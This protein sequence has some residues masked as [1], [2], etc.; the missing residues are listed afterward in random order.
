MVQ[1]K[2][3]RVLLLGLGALSM[4]MTTIDCSRK[5]SSLVEDS[6]NFRFSLKLS[7]LAEIDTVSYT[8]SGNG[9]TPI[10]GMIDVTG[11]SAASAVVSGLPAAM[12]YS[13]SATATSTDGKTK[14]VGDATF[15]IMDGSQTQ[16][17]LILECTG[18]NQS[19]TGVVRV[20]G[21]FDN[22][23]VPTSIVAIPTS[24]QVG[25]SI[26]LIGTYS[27]LD[28]DPV[29]FSWSQSPVNGSLGSLTSDRTTFSCTAV[30][31]ST[32]SFEV[33]DG[34]CAKAGTMTVACV[35]AGTGG[36][37]MGGSSAAGGTNGSGGSGMGGAAASGGSG[38][39]GTTGAGGATST[40]GTG[41][42]GGLGVG[43]ITAAGGSGAGG[44]GLGGSG[45]GGSGTGGSGA[46]GA[47]LGGSAAGGSGSGGSGAGG[48][49]IGGSAAGGSGSGGSGAGG[50]VTCIDPTD[51]THCDS[52]A[53]EQ[54][55]SGQQPGEPNLC[56]S[57]PD[58]C[59]NCDP[60]ISGCDQITDPADK[61]LCENLYAC[62]IAPTHPGNAAFP[63][64]CLGSFGDPLGCWCGSNGLTCA[65]ASS[66]ASQANGPC[67]Q[68]VLAAAK[69]T[70]AATINNNFVL[71]T[72][73]DMT[74]PLP[75]GRATNLVICRGS[76][77][78]SEC[79]IPHAAAK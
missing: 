26:S 17:N 76:F 23:P 11:T 34:T 28:G 43:G 74:T 73:N 33:S 32:L 3:R 16:A 62:L 18:P 68:Q 61:A 12:G 38:A 41:V 65:T 10:S 36:S 4:V 49:G 25:D 6:G 52:L 44:A 69:T 7:S 47:G 67:L 56:D 27:D 39:G 70:D 40:G 22:C 2:F 79:S 21:T 45:T 46:G 35:A 60:S 8:V 15:A 63:G 5:P 58:N 53:C 51:P 9:I 13:I 55:T 77:C 19:G 71:P 31:V 64:S 72:A 14:C 75:L 1:S 66:G 24:A 29:T 78:I 30:G 57:S 42:G 37:G 54:C 50:A 20:D 59:F 48:A